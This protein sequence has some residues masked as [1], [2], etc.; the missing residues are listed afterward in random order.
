MWH[1]QNKRWKLCSNIWLTDKRVVISFVGWFS[2]CVTYQTY[3]LYH[4]KKC[5]YVY[6]ERSSRVFN[7]RK[8]KYEKKLD[9]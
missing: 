3:S 5:I 1:P 9:D 2:S 4:T 7:K 8:E 6:D